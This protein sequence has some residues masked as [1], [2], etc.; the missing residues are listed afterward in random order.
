MFAENLDP[1]HVVLVSNDPANQPAKLAPG[2]VVSWLVRTPNRRVAHL[3]VPRRSTGEQFAL[4]R[5]WVVR[6]A[7]DTR[8][9]AD[10]QMALW[11]ETERAAEQ[12]VTYQ[13]GATNATI[14]GLAGSPTT[15][16][17]NDSV[18]LVNYDYLERGDR[19]VTHTG[20]VH[21]TW[22]TDHRHGNVAVRDDTDQV[23]A[24]GRRDHIVGLVGNDPAA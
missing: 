13:T 3:L 1:V 21:E 19:F 5:G 24:F 20:V 7:H 2:A 12:L 15:R 8:R 22:R 11:L 17:R 10:D 9:D 18:R 14:D 6:E 4:T 23:V 16:Y